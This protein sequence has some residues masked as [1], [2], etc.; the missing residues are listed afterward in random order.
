MSVLPFPAET[1]NCLIKASVGS[2]GSLTSGPNFGILYASK[3][4]SSEGQV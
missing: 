3:Q 2:F 1:F 4:D